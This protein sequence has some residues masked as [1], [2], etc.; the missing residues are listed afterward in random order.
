MIS[1]QETFQVLLLSI[2]KLTFIWTQNKIRIHNRYLTYTLKILTIIKIIIYFHSSKFL[3]WDWLTYNYQ[4]KNL[5]NRNVRNRKFKGSL[6]I[7]RI[8]EVIIIQQCCWL[9]MYRNGWWRLRTNLLKKFL[10]W[11]F[12]LGYFGIR[13]KRS[14]QCRTWTN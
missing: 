1:I 3:V 5:L 8:L 14:N 7:A 13:N 11:L 12:S 10:H 4:I 6:I 2:C 9:G